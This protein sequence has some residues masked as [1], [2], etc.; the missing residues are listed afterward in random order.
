MYE[1]KRYTVPAP[2]GEG[3][4]SEWRRAFSLW[5]TPAFSTSFSP[6]RR[7]RRPGGTCAS[8]ASRIAVLGQPAYLT[9]PVCVCFI[10][11]CLGRF[12]LGGVLL[13]GAGHAIPMRRREWTF[14]SEIRT[15]GMGG[16]I[17]TF[18]FCGKMHF[19]RLPFRASGG[20]RSVGGDPAGIS[21]LPAIMS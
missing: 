17:N 20:G 5:L 21:A 6:S 19:G 11:P 9:Q 18:D 15:G 14:K 16:P 12:V 2:E 4:R 10:A 8:C 1:G 13:D 7:R 3:K